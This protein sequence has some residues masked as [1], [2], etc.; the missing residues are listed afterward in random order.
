MLDAH[1]RRAEDEPAAPERQ[2]QAQPRPPADPARERDAHAGQ[3]EPP[4]RRDAGI[5][6]R[7][8]DRRHGH[9][10]REQQHRRD[11]RERAAPQPLGAA[12]RQ[13]ERGPGG[14]TGSRSSSWP[15][16]AAS[17]RGAS[18]ACA[19]SVVVVNSRHSSGSKA[20]SATP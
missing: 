1:G 11:D 6:R 19:I 10:E 17:T 18:G 13:L 8:G 5:A 7:R 15:A 2:P 16:A 20:P 4:R 12:Q 3:H 9:R 14:A